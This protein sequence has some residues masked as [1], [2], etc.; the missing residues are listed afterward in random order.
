MQL[1]AVAGGRFA[2][3]VKAWSDNIM[4]IDDNNHNVG[5]VGH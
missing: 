2:G 4:E 1:C 5:D 3:A